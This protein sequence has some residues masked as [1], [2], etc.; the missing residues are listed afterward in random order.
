MYVLSSH[1]LAWSIPSVDMHSTG[2]DG[3]SGG[4]VLKLSSMRRTL[5]TIA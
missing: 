4:L 2:R 3:S 1:N 5:P